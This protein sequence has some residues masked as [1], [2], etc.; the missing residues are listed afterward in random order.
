MIRVN[1][2]IITESR[3]FTVAAYIVHIRPLASPIV[4][5]STFSRIGPH[6]SELRVDSDHNLV[7][8]GRGRIDVIDGIE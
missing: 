2:T 7:Y 1:G 5:G 3:S 6:G 4:I 8:L